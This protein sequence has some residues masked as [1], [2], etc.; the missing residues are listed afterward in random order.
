MVRSQH[1]QNQ[2]RFDGSALRASALP[3]K[4]G[5]ERGQT[6]RQTE[7]TAGVTAGSE[8][9][10]MPG[11]R[12]TE[13]HT[14]GQHL[15]LNTTRYSPRIGSS[16]GVHTAR[17]LFPDCSISA[18]A[19]NTNADWCHLP[20]GFHNKRPAEWPTYPKTEGCVES[21][22]VKVIDCIQS[23][24]SRHITVCNSVFLCDFFLL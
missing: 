4:A 14:P 5:D 9:R 13:P 11:R 1:N 22:R 3:D 23:I 16:P 2:P 12:A 21:L 19:A 24:Q 18:A 20:A 8:N 15:S 10:S 7:R 6:D 17:L